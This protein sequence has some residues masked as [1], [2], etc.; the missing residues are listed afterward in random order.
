MSRCSS[1][2]CLNGNCE[3]CR[4]GVK[5][6]NDPRCYPDCPDCSGETSNS[7]VKKRS[8][9]E[10]FLIIFIT[11][12]AIILLIMLAWKFY[13]WSRGSD[14]TVKSYNTQN[15]VME[16][17]YQTAQ[18]PVYYDYDNNDQT[19]QNNQ[20]NDT[21][22][23]VYQDTN[24]QSDNND[25][26]DNNDQV[27]Q[28]NTSDQDNN[29]YGLS[30]SM[31]NPDNVS[32]SSP[33]NNNIANNNSPIKLPNLANIEPMVIDRTPTVASAKFTPYR[34]PKPINDPIIRGF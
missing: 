26:N 23:Q 12:L 24:Y 30:S 16:P 25:N 8:G 6:C 10:W 21:S 15:E 20:N 9:W 14:D 7:S 34:S 22:D 33:I 1:S 17:E 2:A 32:M 19:Y 11:I 27:Y 28:D 18:Y 31:L 5:Y 3:G 29:D 13:T 4:N